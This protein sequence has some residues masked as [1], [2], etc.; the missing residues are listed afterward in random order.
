[1]KI[2]KYTLMTVGTLTLTCLLIGS[3]IIEVKLTNSAYDEAF[4]NAE[5]ISKLE[6]RICILENKA[7]NSSKI[8]IPYMY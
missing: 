7:G 2:L 6:Q 1:M 4:K 8:C 5:A 3:I